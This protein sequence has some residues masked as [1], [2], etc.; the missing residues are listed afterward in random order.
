M[1]D[2]I[3]WM[4]SLLL[5]RFVQNCRW[6]IFVFSVMARST[7]NWSARRRLK[8]SKWRVLVCLTQNGFDSFVDLSSLMCC[9]MFFKTTLHILPYTWSQKGRKKTWHC[10]MVGAICWWPPQSPVP[11]Q[12][13]LFPS[14]PSVPLQKN[15]LPAMIPWVI[16][17]IIRVGIQS[18]LCFT[19]GILQTNSMGIWGSSLT[20]MGL[21]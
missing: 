12:L 1:E 11:P 17:A 9:I 19:V 18:V 16:M 14:V 2:N 15:K 10:T 8:I 7:E 20:S 3:P 4:R 5:R 6:N 21:S 13:C